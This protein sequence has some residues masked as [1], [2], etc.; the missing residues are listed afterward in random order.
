MNTP[1]FTAEGHRALET[2]ILE[3]RKDILETEQG[4]DRS[5]ALITI[6][7][8]LARAAELTQ[9][10]AQSVERASPA[11]DGGEQPNELLPCPFCG[12]EAERIDFDEGENAGGS[13]I[14]CKECNA[15]GNVE[16]GYKE[17]FVSNWNRRVAVVVR[18]SLQK[19]RSS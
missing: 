2:A 8:V 18:R 12:G 6:Q 14:S 1:T 7:V 13:C 16:F 15:S 19:D 9:V 4:A 5:I 3:T 17:N 11:K 10:T